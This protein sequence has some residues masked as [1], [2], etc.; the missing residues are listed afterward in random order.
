MNLIRAE[1]RKTINRF[2]SKILLVIGLWPVLVTVMT[3]LGTGV[4]DF[5]GTKMGAFEFASILLSFQ[6]AIYIPLLITIFMITVS[7]CKEITQKQM[8]IYK[9]IDRKK[10][11]DAKFISITAVFLLYLL[12][13]ISLSFIMY[14]LSF[15][16]EEIAT[17]TFLADKNNVI[18]LLYGS[19]QIVMLC[20]LYI[21]IAF[22]LAIRTTTSI[23]LLITTFIYMFEIIIQKIPVIRFLIPSGYKGE[24]VFEGEYLKSFIFSLILW[25]VYNVALYMFNIKGFR[26]REL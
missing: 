19:F 4:F 14:Y 13:Y 5:K 11:L 26:N 10:V 18:P 16:N 12:I 8:Y 21:N 15:K 24:P 3:R 6:D 9:D 7:V 23:T 1:F 22:T 17:G 2:D 25:G 20:I